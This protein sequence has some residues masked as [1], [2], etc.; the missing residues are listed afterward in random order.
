M[1]DLTTP[2]NELLDKFS[3]LMRQEVVANNHKGDMVSDWNATVYELIAETSY[4]IAKLNKAMLEVE[5]GGV[6]DARKQV[7]EFS[8]DVANYM[9]KTAQIFGTVKLDSLN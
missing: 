1:A 5:R 8:A 7:D 2:Q 6:E 9:A 4:H 3:A